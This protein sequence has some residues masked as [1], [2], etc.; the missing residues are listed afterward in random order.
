MKI[1]SLAA[2]SSIAIALNCNAALISSLTSSVSTGAS[3][4]V[5]IALPHAL[6]SSSGQLDYSAYE[7]LISVPTL[8][9]DLPTPISFPDPFQSTELLDFSGNDGRITS[10]ATELTLSAPGGGT[11]LYTGE[12]T[13]SVNV[14]DDSPASSAS[15][16]LQA[17]GISQSTI[18]FTLGTGDVMQVIFAMEYSLAIAADN[19][20]NA[21]LFWE[22]RGPGDTFI[23]GNTETVEGTEQP[24]GDS[25]IIN[26]V[27][28]YTFTFGAEVPL[29]E[30][31]NSEKG[32]IANIN[33]FSFEVTSIPEPSSAV[34]LLLGG[35]SFLL[36]RKR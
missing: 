4:A 17:K 5:L 6:L 28:A 2:L 26:I 11:F 22:L 9:S 16:K 23:F 30:F 36:R 3:S 32:I 10:S 31:Q 7:G 27:G 1:S 20:N 21:N 25:T 13:N 29:Q 19:K 12:N 34:L 8:P 33:D 14:A 18:E 15:K 35:C 24:V